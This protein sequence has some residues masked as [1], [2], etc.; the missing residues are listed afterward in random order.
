MSDKNSKK[1]YVKEVIHEI[2]NISGFIDANKRKKLKSKYPDL[3]FID[4]IINSHNDSLNRSKNK[5]QNKSKKNS[6][7]PS[8]KSKRK[9]H[10]PEESFKKK[11][12]N[13]DYIDQVKMFRYASRRSQKEEL[14]RF[15]TEEA[16][17]K[18]ITEE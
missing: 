5:S 13:F 10:V 4:V 7:N 1:S 8:N 12:K 9:R 11:L 14:Y 16:G 18:L 3:R 6:Y 2:N 15:L 17:V